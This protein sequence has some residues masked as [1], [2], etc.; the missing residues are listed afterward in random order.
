[1]KV[2]SFTFS[3]KATTALLLCT[4]LVASQPL[5][6]WAENNAVSIQI[7]Q[8]QKV[9][10][11]GSVSD[12]MGPVI[13]ASVVEKG[14]T[15]NGTITDI[16]GNFSLSVETGAVLIVSYIGYQTQEVKVLAGKVLDITLKEDN[17]M[18]EEVVV[19]GYGTQKKKDLTG[20]VSSISEKAFADLA[21]S[22]VTQALS[23]RIPGLDITSG[24]SNP[25][26]K[27]SILMRGH[28]S[29]TASND[30]LIV[31]DG[32]TFYGDLNDINPDDIK[33]IDVLKDASSTAIYG[34]KGANG[35][36]IITTKRGEMGTPKFSFD[37]QLSV[38]AADLIP[39]MNADQWI[40]RLTEGARATGLTGDAL[41]NYVKNKIGAY[42][43]NYY[44]NGG[45]TDWQ[46]LLLQN[47]FRQKYQLSVGGG[48]ERV[49][50]NVAANI[51]S[52]EG[53]LPT[54]KFNRY[55]LR[56][57]IDIDLTK[58]LKI[59]V[60]TLL[61]YNKRHS[62]VSDEAYTD[63]KNLSPTAFPYDE[64]GNLRILA[65][66]TSGWYRNA[67]TEVEN[68]AYRWEN[69]T[70]SAYVNLFADWKIMPWLTYHLNLSADVSKNSDK[71]ASVSESNH[72]HG[73]PGQVGIKDTQNNRESWENILTF[74]KM[75]GEK[76]HLTLTGIHSYQQSHMDNNY[77][78][79]RDIPYFPAL[80][81]NIGTASTVSEYSSDL[82]EWKLLSF[83]ARTF[84]SY[85]DRYMLTASIRAD[86]ASQFA[87]GHKWGYFPSAA[88]AWRISEE[89][90]MKG[91]SSWL[92]NLKLR[93]SYGVSGNQ[94]IT[95]Y[96]TQGNLNSTK[97]SFDD[98]DGLGMRPGEL[99]NKDL[100]WEKTAVYNI[101]LDFGFLNN[102]ITGNMEF[103]LSKTTDLLLYRKL[104]ITTGFDQVLQNVGATQNKGVELAL[105]TH[106]IQNKNFSW[107]TN[108]SFYL[109][110]EEI[111]EL[112]NGKVD[113]VGNRWF[114]GQ[115]ISVYY[116]YVWDGIWQTS[117][118]ETAAKYSRK[119]GEIKVRDLDN[120]NS[121]NDADRQIIGT[122]QPDFVANMTNSF[123][124][125][126]FDLSFELYCRWGHMIEAGI[127]SQECITNCNV[128][129]VNYWTP[130]NG[131][132]EFPRPDENNVSF[133]QGSVLK[134]RDGSFIRLKNLSIG[135]T[136]PQALMKKL[137]LSRARIYLTGENLYTWSKEGL[138]KYNIDLENG[139]T[140]P[141]IRTYTLGLNL[142]F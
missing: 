10:V 15:S 76:H 30:P 41:N 38:Q 89:P 104:P 42:E 23:G 86:G 114:I 14:N 130:E 16:D 106:N 79:V 109:N 39:Y 74:D 95:P 7:V 126:G 87:P 3:R 70:Y 142:S 47:G 97:Y 80:W 121:V 31:L 138:Q 137:H 136:L 90:F 19:V 100:K 116:D 54:R 12:A 55:T 134:Y 6:L 69:T 96:Q 119:P 50:Y 88:F 40:G 45:S 59:G 135:Y 4:G 132:N 66:N 75:F 60:S 92:S 68:E 105:Q 133:Q 8:Q 58:N 11:K 120:S 32:M 99:A 129:N 9:T 21:V 73:D 51:L 22:D 124:Y 27:G 94:G 29:F 140:F 107:D 67:L 101:G 84:Y 82:S 141:I 108:L 52:H 103:Y 128:V 13:G 57:N 112:Y 78:K 98:K 20:A 44:Q 102:R 127:F 118:A 83:A 46:D 56:P 131:S 117:E 36:I 93:L 34:S 33:S 111:V 17:E 24:N 2:D 91:T 25:G 53:V 139:K 122:N 28:R 65:S 81:N 43:W 110:R 123:R 5:S 72:C 18:L 64:E 63:A 85:A 35:V 115:P 1:M 37:T 125:C 62:D 49:K 61:S 113:D 71:Q 26:D 77:I 48:T